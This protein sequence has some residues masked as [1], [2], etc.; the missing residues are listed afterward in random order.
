LL[1]TLS[2]TVAT[3]TDLCNNLFTPIL[4]LNLR[5]GHTALMVA[6]RSGR[7]AVTEYLKSLGVRDEEEEEE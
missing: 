4:T 1:R 3:L 5:R 2:Q 7:E 6:S